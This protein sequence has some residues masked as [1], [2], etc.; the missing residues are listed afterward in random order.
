[1]FSTG[2]SVQGAEL[3]PVQPKVVARRGSEVTL[4]CLG[5]FMDSVDTDV[6]WKFNGK[7]ISGKWLPGEKGNFSLHIT[8]VSEKDV[9]KYNCVAVVANYPRPDVTEALIELELYKSGR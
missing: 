1:M 3:V 9:G 5:S 4:V 8:N 2:V 7:E 6:Y